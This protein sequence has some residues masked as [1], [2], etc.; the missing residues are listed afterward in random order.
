MLELE[1]LFG[2]EGLQLKELRSSSFKAETLNPK[3]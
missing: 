3:P 2:L 1:G